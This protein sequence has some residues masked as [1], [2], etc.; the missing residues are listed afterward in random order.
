MATI[1]LSIIYIVY[2]II[3]QDN[4]TSVH[5]WWGFENAI[6]ELYVHIF[7]SMYVFG[8]ITDLGIYMECQSLILKLVGMIYFK[9]KI[10]CELGKICVH[11]LHFNWNVIIFNRI[12]I[13][14]LICFNIHSNASKHIKLHSIKMY[15]FCWELYK[16]D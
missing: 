13:I 1:T 4:T 2:T 10:K 6:W 15:L 3:K 12:K 9:L 8:I 5:S 16:F 14:D 7:T 11:W